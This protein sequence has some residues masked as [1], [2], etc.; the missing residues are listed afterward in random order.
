MLSSIFNTL[1]YQPFYNAL[2]FLTAILPGGD[3]GFAVIALT[4]VVRFILMPLT[5]KQLHTQRKMKLV[6]GEMSVIKK[7]YENDKQEQTKQMMELYKKHGI[8]PF[9]GFLLIFIQIPVLLA[10]YF[11]FTRGIPFT[12]DKLY[13]FINLPPD[14]NFL[15]LGL[16]NLSTKNYILAIL[17]GVSQYVQIKLS[18]P[19]MAPRESG[20][21]ASF[22][23]ELGRSMS[24]NMRYV[25]PVMIA[26]ISASFPSV[27][28]LYWLTSNI[29]AIIHELIVRRKAKEIIKS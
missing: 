16:I 12:P 20:A 27:V 19:P 24:T 7:K 11:V 23:E 9:S 29:F 3:V 25:M 14:I 21:T 6:E 28:A 18:L 8:N 22:G 2:V 13:S 17:V 1:L 10:L 4:I 5:H 15:F 26:V